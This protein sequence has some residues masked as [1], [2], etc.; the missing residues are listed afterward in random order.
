MGVRVKTTERIVMDETGTYVVQSVRRVPEE[1]RYDHRWL[2]SVRGTPWE[3]N[4]GDVSTDLPEPMLI[5]PQQPDVEPTPTKTY[6]RDSR[7]TRNV[8]IRKMDFEKFGHTAG[9]PACEVHRAGLPMSG[10]GH[11]VECRKRLEDAMT[12]DTLT[13][14]R[15]KATRVRQAE[16]IIK[17]LDDSGAATGSGQHKRV[18]FSDQEHLDSKPEGDTE[19][20]TGG[21]EASVARKR[22]AETDAERLEER[23]AETAETDSDKRIALKRKA[24]GDPSDS[25]MEDSA[26]N[27]LAELWHKEDDP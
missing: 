23:A 5:V 20:Q 14:T 21:Q 18:R 13:A 1:Q 19:M 8:Y 11:T 17:D 24:E 6:H 27:S 4:P 3:P 10:Q 26:M 15:V 7:G 2:Q 9:C 12:T 25:E 22:P 16:R